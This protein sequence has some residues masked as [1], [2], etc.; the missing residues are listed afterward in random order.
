[1][2]FRPLDEPAPLKA[3]VLRPAPPRRGFTVVEWGGLKYR[4]HEPR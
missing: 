2:D 3:Q 4:A 1:M